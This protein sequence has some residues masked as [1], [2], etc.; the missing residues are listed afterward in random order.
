MPSVAKGLEATERYGGPDHRA[1]LKDAEF[2]FRL[3]LISMTW[4]H[5]F[6]IAIGTVGNGI[7]SLNESSWKAHIRS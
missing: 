5:S 7:P 4:D 6:Q 1:Q 2:D 3:L